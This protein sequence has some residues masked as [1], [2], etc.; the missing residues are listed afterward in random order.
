MAEEA[1]KEEKM[2]WFKDKE[3]DE[4]VSFVDKQ[5]ANHPV[6]LAH[7][8]K[9]KELIEWEDGNQFALW[10]STK[11]AV[12]PVTLNV[13]EKQVVINLMKPLNETLEG[14]INFNHKIIGTPN[15]GEQKD[16]RGAQVATKLLD[17]NDAVNDTE[18]LYEDAKYDLLRPGIS[19]IKWY[20]DKSHYATVKKS[21]KPKGSRGRAGEVLGEVVPIFN[22][23]PDPTAK[24]RKQCRWIIEIK[25]VTREELK[26]VYKLKDEWFETTGAEKKGKSKGKETKAA[27]M[28]KFKGMHEELS[29]KDADEPTFILKEYWEI[30]S[31]L[32]SGGRFVAT[33]EGDVLDARENPSPDAE[34]PYFFFM[35]KKKAN[36]FWPRGPLY[37]IQGIQREFNRMVSIQSEHVESWR[38]KMAV[39]KGAIKRAGAFTVDAFEMVEVDFSRGEPRPIQT[40]ELSAQVTLYRDFLVS[41]VDRVSNVHEVSYS[42]LPQYASRAPASLYSMMLEQENVK[43]TPMVKRI[44]KTL[45]E[46][47]RFRLKLMDQHYTV[48]RMIKVVGQHREATIEY[49]SKSDLSQNFDVRLETGVSLHQSPTIQTQ[50]LIQLWREGILTEQDRVKILRTVNLGTA[51]HEIR[52]DMADT[53]R[54]L[55]E[56]QSFIDD[57]YEKK[58]QDGGVKVYWNDDHELHLDYHT[59]FMKSEE[60]QRWDDE[61]WRAFDMHIYEHFKWLS[62]VRKAMAAQL[63]PPTTRP[64]EAPG[65]GGYQTETGE[66]MIEGFSKQ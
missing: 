61:K 38:P 42:R 51:E 41:A 58:R 60:A 32:Y 62:F 50:L 17:Y 55:R 1:K 30:G 65:L 43:L 20:W 27:L 19:C 13:R 4:F 9:W 3:Q 44:N 8:G 45:K 40:P 12:A 54:A 6:V 59:N 11:R 36:S 56:N 25:E 39:G 28:N 18:E 10:D 52:R 2:N 37:F 47:A 22:I 26:R 35:Y 46:M 5:V 29:E 7:H 57:T 48:D 24:S 33:C 15:S 53:D 64:N 31:D 63:A 34:L 49:F 14:K 21:D 66:P 16:I 23:R